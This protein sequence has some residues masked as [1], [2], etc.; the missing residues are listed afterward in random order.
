MSS[1]KRSRQVM[2]QRM[3]SGAAVVPDRFPKMPP[4]DLV[5]WPGEHPYARAL[6]YA[7]ASD[8]EPRVRLDLAEAAVRTLARTRGWGKTQ[9]IPAEVPPFHSASDDPLRAALDAYR[10]VRNWGL[11]VDHLAVA[12]EYVTVHPEQ[13]AERTSPAEDDEIPY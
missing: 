9:P 1:A 8:V 3:T 11:A 13:F 2:R 12:R 7:K 5:Q 4:F 10:W 6:A